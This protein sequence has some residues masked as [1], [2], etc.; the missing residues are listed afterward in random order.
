MEVSSG[1]RENGYE[2]MAGQEAVA[3]GSHSERHW[4]DWQAEES[5]TVKDVF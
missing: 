3:G 1:F 5:I 4:K 2:L